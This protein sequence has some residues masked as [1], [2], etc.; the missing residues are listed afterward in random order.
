MI[1]YFKEFSPDKFVVVVKTS[2]KFYIFDKSCEDTV[3]QKHVTVF[4]HGS[5]QIQMRPLANF[6]L[7]EMPYFF[8]LSSSSL[9]IMNVITGKVCKL[10]TQQ[11]QAKSKEKEEWC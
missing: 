5:L 10:I 9:M 4:F 2:P 8:L 1:G 6:N 11:I 3:F 7:K